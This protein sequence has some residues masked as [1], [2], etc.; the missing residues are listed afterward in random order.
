MGL[1]SKA[2]KLGMKAA[3]MFGSGGVTTL[4]EGALKIFDKF[5]KDKDLVEQL[6]ADEKLA[7]MATD[8]Q[9]LLAEIGFEE[10]VLDLERTAMEG[11][12]AQ[13][14]ADAKS[15]DPVQRRWRPFCSMGLAGL[16]M[17]VMGGIP[18]FRW[19]QTIW[20]PDTILMPESEYT[21]YLIIGVFSL[22]GV[23]MSARTVEKIK[24]IT[25][26]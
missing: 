13:N 18:M 17:W 12:A 8:F 20:Y 7:R 24:G 2:G 4:A 19:L 21:M 22:L 16:L 14:L 15:D 5:T 9:T 3:G 1:L 6:S 26:R 11:I 25:G 23:N 10:N